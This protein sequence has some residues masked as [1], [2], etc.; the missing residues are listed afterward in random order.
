MRASLAKVRFP[1]ACAVLAALPLCFVFLFQEE[2]SAPSR[3]PVSSQPENAVY[4]WQLQWSSSVSASIEK[5]AP[6]HR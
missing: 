6:A 1:L 3:A 5:A 2:V 4:A